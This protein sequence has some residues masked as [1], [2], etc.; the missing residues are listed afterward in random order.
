MPGNGL[1]NSVLND[2]QLKAIDLFVNGDENGKVISTQKELADAVGVDV[3]TVCKWF[4]DKT[5][6]EKTRKRQS[7]QDDE[8]KFAFKRYAPA[9]LRCLLREMNEASSARDRITAA[10][11]IL[12]RAGYTDGLNISFDSSNA[13]KVVRGGYGASVALLSRESSITVDGKTISDAKAVI[14]KNEQYIRN[15]MPEIQC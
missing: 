6:V 14:V 2:K 9:A 11:A 5:F 4:K 13:E 15:N 3:S 12:N 1:N 8:T 10:I 7:S